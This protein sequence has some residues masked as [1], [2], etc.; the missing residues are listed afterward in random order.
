MNTIMDIYA[1]STNDTVFWFESQTEDV[2]GKTLTGEFRDENGNIRKSTFT[3]K[4]VLDI[5]HGV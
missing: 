3:V 2:I 1:L 4:E 5:S